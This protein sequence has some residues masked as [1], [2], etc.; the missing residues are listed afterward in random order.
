M[1]PASALRPRKAGVRRQRSTEDTPGSARQSVTPR[2]TL[3][4]SA[5]PR[6]PPRSL[7]PEGTGSGARQSKSWPM[8]RLRRKRRRA[9]GEREMRQWSAQQAAKSTC[10]EGPGVGGSGANASLV[11]AGASRDTYGHASAR[12]QRAHASTAVCRCLRKDRG[13]KDGR[14]P[15]AHLLIDVGQ[16]SHEQVKPPV[17]VHK[18]AADHLVR[19]EVVE[20]DVLA[21]VEHLVVDRRQSA[22]PRRQLAAARHALDRHAH[23]VQ[24]RL[25]FQLHH[26]VVLGRHATWGRDAAVAEPE[27]AQQRLEHPG[28]Q[29]HRLRPRQAPDELASRQQ[30]LLR[31]PRVRSVGGDRLADEEGQHVQHGPQRAAQGQVALRGRARAG[32]V[33]DQFGRVASQTF[34]CC[35]RRLWWRPAGRSRSWPAERPVVV[36]VHVLRA[37]AGG[38]AGAQDVGGQEGGI[39]WQPRKDAAERVGKMSCTSGWAACGA[40]GGAQL[41]SAAAPRASALGGHDHGRGLEGRMR[42]PVSPPAVKGGCRGSAGRGRTRL[43]HPCDQCDT[44]GGDKG[45]YRVPVVIGEVAQHVTRTIH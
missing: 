23:L 4:P 44:V 10:A 41:G 45:R 15:A 13:R 29:Q 27:G 19:V 33:G 24:H 12:G 26:N 40:Q 42:R 20:V 11:G 22:Q 7:R 37:G 5:S 39:W 2:A 9:G 18:Q 17:H 3:P 1:L 36:R 31:H 30:Q 16:A 21:H 6:A 43:Q 38:S 25:V 34:P 35:P 32:H 28:L 14:C 8:P